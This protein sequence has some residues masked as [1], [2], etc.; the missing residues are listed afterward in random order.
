MRH[1]RRGRH[2]GRN[3]SHR[4]AMLKNLVKS[5]ILTADPEAEANSGAPKINGRIIT[6][7]PKAKEVRPFVEKCVTIAIKGLA[8][9]EKA[10]DLEPRAPRGS[11]EWHEWRKGEGWQKW[12]KA[13]APAVTA[14]RR[15]VSLLS[16][17]G[18][19]HSK[20]DKRVIRVLFD[21]VAPQ[22]KDRPGG[23]TRILK[24]AQPR[25][26]DAGARAILE[27]VGKH[28]RKPTKSAAPKFVADAETAGDEPAA[29]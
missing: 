5:L 11:A 6:T 21:H 27:F 15:L 19:K 25:L 28:D 24:L 17:V 14:R 16:A 9:E 29:E 20:G 22:F 12:A 23:Y 10:R 3:P 2:L 13:M 26:G 8:A 1:R 4:K 7:L 18:D